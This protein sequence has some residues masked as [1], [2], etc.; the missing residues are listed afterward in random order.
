MQPCEK[1][2]RV[3]GWQLSVNLDGGEWCSLMDPT[4]SFIPTIPVEPSQCRYCWL[5]QAVRSAPFLGL[6]ATVLFWVM[7]SSGIANLS[8]LSAGFMPFCSAKSRLKLVAFFCGFAQLFSSLEEYGWFACFLARPEVLIDVVWS[9]YASGDQA[10]AV[11]TAR[12]WMVHRS[13][14]DSSSGGFA[15]AGLYEHSMQLLFTAGRNAQPL[16]L[17]RVLYSGELAVWSCALCIRC[18]FHGNNYEALLWSNLLTALQHL[19]IY[20]YFLTKC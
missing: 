4:P 17:K 8:W 20:Y 15:G 11:S 2:S 14:G 6:A 19:P 16:V 3:S 13:S 7:K 10:V 5:V 1:M 12:Q 18:T 9:Q